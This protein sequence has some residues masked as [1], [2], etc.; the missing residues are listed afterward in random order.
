MSSIKLNTRLTTPFE[1]SSSRDWTEYPRP[2]FVRDSYFSLCG[3]W[4]LYLTD[5]NTRKDLG[6]IKVPFPPESRISGIERQLKKGEKYIYKKHFSLPEDMRGKK[7]ALHF[8]AVDQIAS[9][10]LNGRALGEHTGGY[11]PFSF[12]IPPACL[13]KENILTVTVTDELDHDLAWGKQRRDRGGMWYTPISGIWQAVWL[14]A[15]PE[16]HFRGLKMTPSLTSVRIEVFGGREQKKLILDAENRVVDFTGDSIELELSEPHAWTPEDPYLYYFT[17][18]DGVDEIRSYFALRTVEIKKLGSN[19]YICLNGKPYYFHGLLDQGYYSDGIYTPYSP[20][21]LEFDILKM[22]ELGFNML[23]K[24][25]KIEHE[26]FYHYCDK[27][28][29]IVFQDMV[30]SGDYSFIIDTALPTAGLKKGIS[31]KAGQKRRES[32]KQ[33]SE[34][35]V[36]LLYNH[37]S[38]CYYTIFNEGWGQFD[39]DENYK[40]LKPLDATRVFDATSGWFAESLSDVTSDHIYF[41]RLD[42]KAREDRPLVLSEFGGYSCKIEDHSFNL[43]KT[44]G[45]GKFEDASRFTDAF[46]RLYK[47]E[48]V[49]M[50]KRGLC[51]SVY[52][53]V[54]DVEDET[55]GLLTYDRQ[56][57]KTDP[58]RMRNIAKMI[59]EAFEASVKT[60]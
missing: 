55:N 9:V 49:P 33:G 6:R 29:M 41:K 38:V 58:E 32:F 54:S 36:S 15:L 7:L 59:K 34:E 31:H 8:G 3:D 46:E 50:I 23:R 57:V 56:A 43:S 13:D 27:H 17:L 19:S 22:K 26:L 52:T 48:V 21:G 24:H 28:G 53:Q 4:Q 5:K 20:E 40:R 1:E 25:I 37:P 39:A 12:E 44:Y 35:T 42:M 11:L 60:K 51:A 10:S 30:N 47:E 45:Y 18:S 14:E 2:Q 16:N